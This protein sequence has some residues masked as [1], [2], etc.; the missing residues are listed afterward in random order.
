[1]KLID[2]ELIVIDSK[3]KTPSIIFVE[4]IFLMVQLVLPK[5]KLDNYYYDLHGFTFCVAFPVIYL[6]A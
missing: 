4:I 2:L 3:T 6:R 5:K 1:M